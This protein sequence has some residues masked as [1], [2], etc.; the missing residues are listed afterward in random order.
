MVTDRLMGYVVISPDM[1][2]MENQNERTPFLR[3]ASS[4]AQHSD[5]HLSPVDRTAA[6]QKRRLAGPVLALVLG[7]GILVVAL[8][9]VS[10]RASSSPDTRIID[11]DGSLPPGLDQIGPTKTWQCGTSSLPV[12]NSTDVVSY[13]SLEEGEAAVYGT[14]AHEAMFNG[15]LFRFVSAKNK[16]LFEVIQRLRVLLPH[17]D[18]KISDNDV[19]YCIILLYIQQ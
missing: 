12:L 4:C 18:L 19:S 2:K 5:H 6:V 13:F 15:Y 3:E 10:S 17:L 8:G 14:K 9:G 7:V 11:G 1:D 16:A